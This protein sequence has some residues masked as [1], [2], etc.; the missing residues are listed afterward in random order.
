MILLS[1]VVL[2]FSAI[3]YGQ[4][5]VEAPVWNARDKWTWKN[6]N[7][8]TLTSEVVKAEGNFYI[9]KMEGDPDLY[10]YD[11]KTMNINL[12]LKEDGRRFKVDFYWRKVLDF[13]MF[14]GKSW[15]DTTFR[16][17]AGI[18][19][20]T[21]FIH[22]FRIDGVENITT[23]AGAFKCY[24]IRLK[25]TNLRTH[26]TG[27]IYYWYSPEVKNWIKQEVENSSFWMRSLD[28]R[29]EELISYILK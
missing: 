16:K 15:K 26:Y 12:L 19:L 2:L 5:K 25:L 24:K 20:E 28:P 3:L 8:A 17:P 29:N 18:D 27:W 11:K 22:E 6:A 4:D 14:V 9:V 21:T 7:G 1:F 10:A 23:T 13:P